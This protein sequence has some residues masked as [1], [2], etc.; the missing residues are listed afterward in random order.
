MSEYKAVY[1]CR[2][3]GERFY[4]MTFDTEDNSIF[5]AMTNFIAGNDLFGM[6]YKKPPNVIYK[7][8][9]HECKDGSYGFA[10]FLGFI[11]VDEE[12]TTTI[13][14]VIHFFE[15]EIYEKKQCLNDENLFY[16]SF[17]G[18]DVGYKKAKQLMEHYVQYCQNIINCIRNNSL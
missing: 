8:E 10:D 5:Y 7:A 18:V 4:G 15:M 11:N 9:K 3:C 2:L 16:T 12:F 6:S 14:D 13:D 17:D 1:K